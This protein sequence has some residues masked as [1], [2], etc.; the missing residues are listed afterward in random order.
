MDNL[1]YSN[2]FERVIM[3]E[4]VVENQEILIIP[5]NFRFVNK[6]RVTHVTAGDF[7]LELD[8]STRKYS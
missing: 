8:F 1:I 5:Q 3:R 6:G 4:L 2:I 7:T